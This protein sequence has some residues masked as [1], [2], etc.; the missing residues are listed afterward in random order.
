[1]LSAYH[2][3]VS[4]QGSHVTRVPAGAVLCGMKISDF[5][6][7]VLTGVQLEMARCESLYLFQSLCRRQP[8]RQQRAA[9]WEGS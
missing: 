2:F 3:S 8:V 5:N 7:D 4:V 1:M 9:L 6:A